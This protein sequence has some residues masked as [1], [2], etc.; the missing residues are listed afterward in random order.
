MRPYSR[1]ITLSAI[2][3]EAEDVNLLAEDRY[4]D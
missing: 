2:L 4:D 3:I 1:E